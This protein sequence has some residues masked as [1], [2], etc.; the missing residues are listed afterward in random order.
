MTTRRNATGRKE[1]TKGP[2]E[3]NEQSVRP[4]ERGAKQ[5]Q[6]IHCK[7]MC[8]IWL[9][10]TDWLVTPLPK[11]MD[12]LIVPSDESWFQRAYQHTAKAEYRT[13]ASSS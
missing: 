6:Y 9:P 3:S 12:S 5:H 7:L 1:R 2:G 4:R 13:T 11:S 10:V 8:L